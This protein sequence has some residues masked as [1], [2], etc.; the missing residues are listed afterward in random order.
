[1]NTATEASTFVGGAAGAWRMSR[2]S[3]IERSPGGFAS[4]DHCATGRVAERMA[5]A[6]VVAA[7]CLRKTSVELTLAC[8]RVRG[9]A[10]ECAGVRGSGQAG[11]GPAA[12]GACVQGGGTAAAWPGR[13]VDRARGGASGPPLSN[14]A[15]LLTAAIR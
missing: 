2:C 6:C 4:A 10:R 9:S 13:R 12:V 8:P 1:M 7:A 3:G 15:L 14:L 11:P 5:R